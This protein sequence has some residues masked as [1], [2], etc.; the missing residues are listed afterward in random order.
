M[1][2]RGVHLIGVSIKRESTVYRIQVVAPVGKMTLQFNSG[3]L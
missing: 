1:F 2:Y 3:L